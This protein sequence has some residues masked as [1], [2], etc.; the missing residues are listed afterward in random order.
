MPHGE[1][2]NEKRA[3]VVLAER[4]KAAAEHLRVK[5]V[6][7]FLGKKIQSNTREGGRKERTLAGTT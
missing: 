1:H 6:P 7:G 2:R 5:Y 4:A 3:R